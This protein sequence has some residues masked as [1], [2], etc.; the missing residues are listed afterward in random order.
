M[1]SS[2]FQSEDTQKRQFEPVEVDSSQYFNIYYP[3]YSVIDLE[4]GKMPSKNNKNVIMV[5]AAAYTVNCL[6]TFDH[7]NI[8]GNHIS[9][10]V[11]F[12]GAPSESYRG[13]FSFYDGKPHFAYDNWVED[14]KKAQTDG[15]GFAQDMMIHNGQIVRSWRNYNSRN[16]FRALCLINN[17]IAII[18]SKKALP[19][20]KFVYELAKLGVWEAIYL[21][22]GGWKHSWYRDANGN[23]IDIFP[24]PNKYA[25]N[26]ITF[27]K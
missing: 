15:C 3:N 23:V 21:D 4:C 16:I 25:T 27:Y 20:G 14:F 17:R 26:W 9:N 19:F 22:M 24:N 13:A 6:D 2:V 8:I 12:N 5:C 18:D 1:D 11:F 10:G 7:K